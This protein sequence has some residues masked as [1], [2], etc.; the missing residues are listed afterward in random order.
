MV[1]P[2]SINRRSTDMT[3]QLAMAMAAVLASSPAWTSE[4][5]GSPKEEKI[6]VGSGAAIGAM[7]GGPIGLVLGAA[8]GGWLGDRFH[9]ERAQRMEFEHAYE[10]ASAD[11]DSFESLLRGSE[12]ELVTLRATLAAEQRGF[13]TA[14][15]EALGVQVYFRTEQSALDETTQKRLAQVARVIKDVEDFSIVIEGHADARGDAEYNAELSEQ[16]A[17]AVREV[18]VGAGVAPDRITVRAAGE[19]QSTATEGDVDALALERRATLT[20]VRP[21]S[22]LVGAASGSDR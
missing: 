14:L 12:R 2:Q 13:K 22:V 9:Q 10:Q 5:N 1:S 6:G 17:A 20:I 16:R 15:E 18:L 3:K 7:A 4:S 11:A 19:S 8:F 21:E